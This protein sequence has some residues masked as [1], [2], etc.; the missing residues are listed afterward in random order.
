MSEITWESII[1]GLEAGTQRAAYRQADGTWQANPLVKEAILAAFR[2]GEVQ[3]MGEL[4]DGLFRGFIDKHTLVPR[5]F[6]TQDKVRVVPGGSAIRRG[7]YLGQGVVVM[8]PAYVN[9]GAYVGNNT[10]IDSHVLVGSCA[11]IGARV[12]LSAGVQIGGVL[13]PVGQVPVVIEDDVFV[14]AGAVIVEGITVR[15]RAV[16]APG[17]V[18]SRAVKVYDAVAERV[19][20][21]GE[22]I[23][24][25]AVVVPGTR[26]LLSD[27]GRMENLQISTPVIIK[28]R[29]AKSDAA[30]TL[31]E[32]LR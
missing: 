21:R 23:P 26:P 13:E 31:E 6:S 7:A 11:Q 4:S 25:G 12:H 10:M 5:R 28:Y 19:L 2:F 17:V 20:E 24:E 30:L 27:W 32:A 18:L 16:I 8:P 9:V 22:A 1:D 29:D 3:D 14:G 15:S